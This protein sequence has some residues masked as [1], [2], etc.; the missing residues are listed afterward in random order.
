LGSSSK[1]AKGL[2]LTRRK[3][4]LSVSGKHRP[5]CQFLGFANFYRDFI[6]NFSEIPRPLI[7]LT[8]KDTVFY[9]GRNEQ[10]AFE[11][12]REA[13]ISAPILAQ[14]DS[15]RDT[16][17]EADASGYAIGGCLSQYDDRKRL[18]PVAYLSQRLSPA[19]CNYQIHD[20]EL[21]SI[22]R[23]LQQWD[24]KLRSTAKT[25]TI[26]SDYYNLKYFMTAKQLNERQIR[27]AEILSRYNFEIKFRPGSKAHRP[28]ALSRRNQDLPHNKEDERLQGR[29]M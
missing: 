6:D 14:W 22:I 29:I 15:E 1:L 28:D 20:K 3:Y 27:W 21:L 5:L 17:V 26:L 9:W 8:K 7:R 11:T 25:F 18:K 16:V 4:E 23:A 2:M 24:S 13:F 10:A 12:L 19:E